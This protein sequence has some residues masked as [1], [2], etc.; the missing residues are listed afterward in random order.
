MSQSALFAYYDG[1]G[2]LSD[3][4]AREGA[5]DW[6][7]ALT[8]AVRGGSTSGEILSRT[9]VVLRDLAKSPDVRRYSIE[10]EVA[11]LRAECKALWG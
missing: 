10:A 7:E 8:R 5:H 6:S 11:R 1:I 4:L 9:G 2:R 3:R